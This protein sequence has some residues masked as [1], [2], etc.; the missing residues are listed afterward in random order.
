M[1]TY[2]FEE[3][4]IDGQ[5]VT[6]LQ[7]TVL[8]NPSFT[9]ERANNFNVGLDGIVLD[10]KLSFTLEYFLNKRDQILIQKT[11]STPGS[12]GIANLLPP[13]NAGKVDNK[14]YEFALNYYG[15]NADGFKWDVGING[16]QAKNEVV[17]LDEV[18][19]A[20]EYQLQEGKPI[21]SYL[22]YEADGAFLDEAAIA[23]NTLGL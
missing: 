14:G 4:P 2:G 18:P 16:G 1:S 12:S 19:G 10:G 21:N 20:P 6:T 3:F 5:V 13:V 9:W 7:E 22:V 8:A 15:G 17:F 11:G 23:A